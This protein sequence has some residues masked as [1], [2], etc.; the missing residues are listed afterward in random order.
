V[1]R[2]LFRIDRSDADIGALKQAVRTLP[3]QSVGQS[4]H[5]QI[6]TPPL[7]TPGAER[8]YSR[9]NLRLFMNLCVIF[10]PPRGRA[11][12]TVTRRVCWPRISVARMKTNLFTLD[13]YGRARAADED[14][15]ATC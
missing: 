8:H 3:N 5:D 9:N 14:D 13:R 11:S 2:T 10:R 15:I 7:L 1:L 4:A 6:N 12:G